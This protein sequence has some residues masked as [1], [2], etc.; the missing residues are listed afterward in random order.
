MNKYLKALGINYREE[1][2]GDGVPEA[3]GG[4]TAPKAS[5]FLKADLAKARAKS[6]ELAA[7]LAKFEGIDPDEYVAMRTAR[8][9]DDQEQAA[10]RGEFDK[11]LKAEK[12]KSSAAELRALEKIAA[13]NESLV[14]AELSAAFVANGGKAEHVDNFLILAK[15]KLVKNEDGQY[16][17]PDTFV[18]AKGEAISDFK[19]FTNQLAST[20][21]GFAFNPTNNAAGSGKTG[22]QAPTGGQPRTVSPAEANQYLDEIAGGTVVVG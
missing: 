22:G 10:K 18:N 5:D 15:A 20:D 8:E 2:G 13:A 4:E 11:L 16:V 7:Q 6:K 17:V 19:S 1:A 12:D 21:L 3:G 9:K 14:K